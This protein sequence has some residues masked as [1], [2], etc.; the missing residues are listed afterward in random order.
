VNGKPE[1]DWIQPRRGVQQD[2]L[3]APMLFII[4]VNFLANAYYALC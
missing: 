3:L 4:V 1:D 2:F